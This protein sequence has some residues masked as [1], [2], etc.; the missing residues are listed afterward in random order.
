MGDLVDKIMAAAAQG[1]PIT[2]FESES[3]YRRRV[4]TYVE[5]LWSAEKARSRGSGGRQD[6]GSTEAIQQ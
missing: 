5:L 1:Q 4:S 6:T 3:E 2:Y